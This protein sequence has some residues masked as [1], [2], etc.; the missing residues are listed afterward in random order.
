MKWFKNAEVS[1]EDLDKLE[2]VKKKNMEANAKIEEAAD[3]MNEYLGVNLLNYSK[4]NFIDPMANAQIGLQE[5]NRILDEY[6]KELKKE[7]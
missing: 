7:I 6:I 3:I 2:D 5:A 4:F 1:K